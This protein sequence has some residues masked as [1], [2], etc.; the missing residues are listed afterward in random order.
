MDFG[1]GLVLSFTD[2]ASAGLN[3]ASNSL[4]N[5]TTIA[6]QASNS[7]GALNDTV[8]LQ[9]T[10]MSANMIGN[11]LVS[12][13]KKVTGTFLNLVNRVRSTGQEYEDFGITLNAIYKD[14]GKANTAMKKLMDFSVRSP[15]EVGEVKDFLITLKSQGIEPFEKLKGSVTG[16]RQETL[17]WIT[18]L[19]S[20][21]P[22]IPVQRFKMAIQNYVGSGEKKMMRTVFDLGDITDIIG[23]GVGKTASDRMNDIV[24]MVEKTNLTGLSEKLAV[25][26]T[27]VAS[28][29]DDA[30]T[31]LFKTIADNG[32][33][34]NLK[35]SFLSLS[36][37]IVNMPEDKLQSFGKTLAEGLNIVVKPL[38][39]F[40]ERVSQ[41]IDKIIDLCDTHPNLVK[42]GTVLIAVAGA[43]LLLGGVA[44]KA[45]GALANFSLVLK[46]LNTTSG[47]TFGI[48]KKG[49][50]SIT[51]TMLPLIA[52][53]G[54]LYLAWTRDFGGIRTLLGGY[55]KNV[56]DSFKTASNMVN[57]SAM[58]MHASLDHLNT[59]KNPWDRYTL[60]FA[61]FIGI[62]KFGI[63]AMNGYTLSEESWQKANQ[64]GILPVIESILELKYRFEN[65]SA[66]FKK[67]WSD[68]SN[69][70]KT[71][72]QGII[73]SLENTPFDG[74]ITKFKNFLDL[75][76]SSDA[77][78][79]RSSGEVFAHITAK[80]LG[81]FAVFKIVGGV[82]SK[83]SRLSSVLRGFTGGG[84]LGRVFGGRNGDRQSNVGGG[85]ILSNPVKVFKT[86]SSLAIII[87]GVSLIIAGLGALASLPYFNTFMSKGNTL[88]P[89]LFDNIVPLAIG[90]G[91]LSLLF[92][93]MEALNVSV[94][95]ALK[96]IANLAI[97]LGGVSLIAT[98]LGAL[99]SV[100][101]FST[102]ITSGAKTMTTIATTLGNM[103]SFSLIGTIGIISALGVI[104]IP[105]VL[106]GLANFALI[107]GGI[108]GVIE[109]F[110]YLSS[111]SGFNEF[112]ASG[113]QTLSLLFNQLGNILGS[114]I[115]GFATGVTD[116]LPDIANNLSMFGTNLKPFFNSLN[117]APLSE[118]G[119]FARGIGTFFLELGAQEVLKAIGGE[120]DLVGIANQLSQ[121]GPLA[122]GFFDAVAS[123][124]EQGIA[125]AK[126]VFEAL[127]GLGS[128]SFKSGGFLQKIT[129]EVSLASIGEQLSS[130]APNGAIF[131]SEVAGYNEDGINK[132]PMVFE[133]LSG[134]GDYD[135]KSGGF[136]QKITGEVSLDAIGQQLASFSEN[137]RTFFNAVAGYNE[138]GILKARQVFESLSYIGNLDF[139]SGGWLQEIIGETSLDDLGEQLTS[140]ANNSKEFFTTMSGVDVTNGVSVINAI[141]TIGGLTTGGLKRLIKGKINISEVGEQLASFGPNANAFFTSVQDLSATALYNG[142][143]V[144]EILGDGAYD[145]RSGGFL[146]LFTGEVA[147]ESIGLQLASFAENSK[148][149]FVVAGELNPKGFDNAV[150]IFES[151]ES[152]GSVVDIAVKSKGSLQSFGKELVSFANSLVKFKTTSNKVG[153]VSGT[154]NGMSTALTGFSSTLDTV[155][156]NV[157]K[158]SNTIT[159]SLSKMATSVSRNLDEIRNKFSNCAFKFPEF[160]M[161]HFDVKGNFNF[162]TVPPTTPTM[163]VNWYKEGGVFDKPTFI[164]V[165]EAGKEAVVPLENNTGWISNLSTQLS[166]NLS[167]TGG[168]G[169][170]AILQSIVQCGTLL[171][172]IIQITDS[173]RTHV[174]YEDGYDFEPYTTP[175]LEGGSITSID[176]TSN[177]NTTPTEVDNSVHFSKGSIVINVKELSY[178]EID[179][180][181]DYI[182]RKIKRRKEINDHM[183]YKG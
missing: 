57:G 121:F 85:G 183:K 73:T 168:V 13:G 155:S 127:G 69:N 126:L 1:L 88:I 80:A 11:G 15:L 74:L 146:S 37:V 32:V 86:M 104:P 158:R 129:G 113:G 122:S 58:E 178:A 162:S 63:E 16:A 148:K 81:F 134:I 120:I 125:N 89:K 161:P 108:T 62:F 39:K 151:L 112:L 123:Y 43:I 48:I 4:M 38:S 105:V 29:V 133:A 166:S 2:N 6:E 51:K 115:G 66:G 167:G 44:F 147:L 109:A 116:S 107:L 65:F 76:N 102:F 41:G 98:A 90:I 172:N 17:A 83:L 67:G 114:A 119:D 160:K 31:K 179:A 26:W 153:N 150:K 49:L 12:M 170:N 60:S 110:G 174:G 173:I 138:D 5:L 145:F 131:F 24:E 52:V 33:F 9:A 180:K 54:L 124:P 53:T 72:T 28:N 35:G 92:K 18:D 59:V 176:N 141:S 56:S 55:V 164:G 111:I 77:D 27:G 165:G 91:V 100:P 117:G 140:F 135:L 182:I 163:S 78:R 103:F 79:W 159:S 132:A 152:M 25:S 94:G 96:G 61:K 130:F 23:H 70:V 22:E 139:K 30:F 45:I 93:G 169:T 71:F 21:K 142:S 177:V 156:G 149:F 47:S 144:L 3:N 7:L 8:A 181:I 97:I 34:E 136:L 42:F 154:F 50:F 84:L 87:S 20:F 171:A 106:A 175:Q 40:V 10:A 36:S 143:R 99:N 118:I 82:T 137:G 157:Q 128:Y 68:I 19:K 101:G 64:L 95:T 46:M 75:F 14:A